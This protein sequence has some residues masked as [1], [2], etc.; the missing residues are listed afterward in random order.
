M[1][2]KNKTIEL[3]CETELP[4][5]GWIQGCLNCASKTSKT[6]IFKTIENHK[7]ILSFAIYI[8]KDCKKDNILKNDEFT[9]YVHKKIDKKYLIP[10]RTNTT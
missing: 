8:C 5:R 7:Y 10:G 1:T 2:K 3:Y 9:D 6:H 4:E